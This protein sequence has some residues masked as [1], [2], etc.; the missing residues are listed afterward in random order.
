APVVEGLDDRGRRL[1]RP[2]QLHEALA[3]L[4]GPRLGQHQVGG[5]EA[6]EGGP[7]DAELLVGSGAGHVEELEET[8]RALADG[9]VEVDPVVADHH[10]AAEAA[11][12][13]TAPPAARPGD[14]V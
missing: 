4:D 2:Q 3:G 10:A 8:G 1:A 7:T 12:T 5:G 11:L 6:L 14:P 9:L 13:G